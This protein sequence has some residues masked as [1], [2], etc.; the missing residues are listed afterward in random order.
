MDSK[1]LLQEKINMQVK[2]A[3]KNDVTELIE[4]TPLVYLNNICFGWLRSTNCCQ[5]RVNGTLRLCKG[6]AFSLHFSLRDIDFVVLM[7][8]KSILKVHTHLILNL[9]M[10]E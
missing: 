6:Q 9:Y 1:S 7:Q 5:A 10:Q 4:N 3:I 8:K 2:F